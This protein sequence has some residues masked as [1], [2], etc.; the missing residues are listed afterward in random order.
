MKTI[1]LSVTHMSASEL[2]DSARNE[3]IIVRASDGTPFV[4][5]L[6]DDFVTEVELLRQN[7]AFL[8]LLDAY[9]QE[10]KTLSLE[11]VEERLR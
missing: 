5:S 7:H 1:D 6:A 8:A 4:L 11:E 2:L 9:K 3:S 10:Q